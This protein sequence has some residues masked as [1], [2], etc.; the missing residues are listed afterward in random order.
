[1]ILQVI[2]FWPDAEGGQVRQPQAVCDV[3]EL[4]LSAADKIYQEFLLKAIKVSFSGKYF[5]L[6]V[7]LEFPSSVK[8]KIWLS[9]FF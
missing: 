1:M 6:T 4:N 8:S 2:T 7:S 9:D 3:G 5:C